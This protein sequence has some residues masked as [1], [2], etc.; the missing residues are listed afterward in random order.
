M[1]VLG[2]FILVLLA[3]VAPIVDARK[4]CTSSKEC[5]YESA[6]YKGHCYT[7]DEMFET[8]DMK[9]NHNG[10]QKHQFKKFADDGYRSCP[11]HE[12]TS[13]RSSMFSPTCMTCFIDGNDLH[14]I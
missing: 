12:I 1:N 11:I 4:R 10:R 7:V 2:L 14:R 9:K 13:P 6:C 3:I 8:F 5:D